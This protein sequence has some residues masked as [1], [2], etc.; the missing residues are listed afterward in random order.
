ML[1]REKDTHKGC[2]N[3]HHCRKDDSKCCYLVN[4]DCMIE[5]EDCEDYL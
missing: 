1:E 2:P 4:N 5:Y 3:R